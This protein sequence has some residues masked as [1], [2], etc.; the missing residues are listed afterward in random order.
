MKISTL[1]AL[2]AAKRERRAVALITNT[3]TGAERIVARADA[4][5][6]SDLEKAFRFDKSA[7]AGDE[8]IGI[9][10]PPLRLV[11]IGA[12]LIAQS[13]I[14]IAKAC[15]YDITV[16][17]PRGAFATGARFPDI[18]LLVDWPQDILPKLKLDA[19]TGLIALAHDPKI[20]DPTLNMALC[21]E[22]FYIGALGSKKSH[23]ARIERL[24][25]AG[26]NAT[27]L[28]R[29]AGPIGLSIGAVGANEIAI[30]IMAQMTQALR[31]G[32]L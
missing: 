16:I 20:D 5:A 10:N 31:L 25:K 32:R 14:P 7:M 21:S 22:A 24:T 1:H 9:H 28:A 6:G 17:D 3:K 26:F 15:G 11:I 30:S 27:D 23:A 4:Q 19:R 29:I 12:V 2:N 13:I 18:T 8:F